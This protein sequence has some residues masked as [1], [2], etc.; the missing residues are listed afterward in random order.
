MEERWKIIEDW[1]DYKVSDSGLVYSP[2]RDRL[3]KTSLNKGYVVVNLQR[4]GLWKQ[5]SVH[6]LVALAFVDG[7]FEGADVN[8]IDGD[9]TNNDYRNL[10]WVTRGG[11]VRHAYDNGLNPGRGPARGDRVISVVEGGTWKPIS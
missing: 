9:K 4:D 1:P 5:V 3:L 2:R 7:W 10:E 11:N 6:R 8:H